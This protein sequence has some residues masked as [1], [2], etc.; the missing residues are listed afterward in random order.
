MQIL[1]R[2]T[3]MALRY[4]G[5]LGLAYLTF[6]ASI[7]FSMLVVWLLGEAINKIVVTGEGG[8]LISLG[9]VE[10]STL[11]WMAMG[12]MGASLLR[13][14]F[15]FARTYTTDSLSQKVAYDV[16]NDMYD[17]LQHLSFAFHDK[18]H[19]GNLMSKVTADI[20]AVRRF[21]MMGLVR[22]FEVG[23]RVIAITCILVFLNWELTLMSL[24]FVPFLV[25]RSTRVQATMRVL[26]TR[27]QEIT[28]QS[29]TILQENLS[30]IHVVKAFAAENHESEKYAAK[31]RELSEERFRSE[32]LQGTES[33]QMTLYFTVA[34]GLVL[35]YGGW[36]V[37]RGDLSAGGFT[38]FILLLNQ[39]TFPIRMMPF[40]INSFSRAIS[41]GQRL[42]EVLDARSPVEES[43]NAR[44]MGRSQGHVRFNDVSFSYDQQAPA[45]DHINLSVPPGS[46]VA[47]LGAPGS[48][49]ST[50]VNLLPRFY[51]ATQGQIT[52]DENDIQDFTLASLRRNVGIVQQDVFLFT[53][54]IKKNIAYGIA[55]ASLEDVVR[56]AKVAQLHDH[57]SSLPDGYDTWVGERGVT[58]SGGQRQ[59][60]SMAR[61]ILID[62]P[63]LILDDS[64]SSVDVE[65]ERL[66]HRAMTQVMK[67]RTT[68]IIAH[69]LSSVREADLILVLKDGKIVEQGTH[70][71]LISRGGIYQDIYELQLR[72]QEEVLLD[73]ALPAEAH[74]ALS[75]QARRP[76]SE[77]IAG[78]G[79]GDG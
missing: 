60:L 36:E 16:R 3:N 27:V 2:I 62:P 5:R 7:S 55:D 42:F 20:E 26:W 66:I 8:Q 49:K 17:K 39:L 79:G 38:M 72:P 9:D 70:Q 43:P 46:V 28:G 22:S 73:A 6:F 23:I 24:A 15:D 61:T 33:A 65:T 4:R 71:E 32:R 19:T 50:I 29:V 10:R 12:L 78:D 41:S 47:L 52:I 14:I 34:L 64:T 30:G 25:Y 31:A 56:A 67:G 69:R 51:D 44:E 68:F 1:L 57:I 77:S 53:A 45:L 76:Q 58:L 63:V 40:I 74:S 54:S 48:G 59:R 35:W 11:L 75:T 37:I 21:I 18:E 13:G